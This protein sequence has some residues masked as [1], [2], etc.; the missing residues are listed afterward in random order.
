MSRTAGAGVR[1]RAPR[2]W[3]DPRRASIIVGAAAL[4][5][6][7]LLVRTASIHDYFWMD[8]GLSVGIASHPF[9]AIPALLRQD[10]SPPL[11]YALLHSGASL[12]GSGEAA[13]HALSL[14]FAT[15]CVPM[16]GWPAAGPFGRRAG[17]FAAVLAA[18]NPLLSWYSQE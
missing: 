8:E 17:V 7:S 9:G 11:S 4:L 14:L 3:I 16:A 10:G 5:G 18:F 13:T 12:F 1:V 6:L 2:V 15:L